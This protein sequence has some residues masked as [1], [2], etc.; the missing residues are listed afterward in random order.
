M[1]FLYKIKYTF[2]ILLTS[3]FLSTCAVISDDISCQFTEIDCYRFD[4]T[5]IETFK[6]SVEDHSFKW[7]L[8]D[9]SKALSNQI[10]IKDLSINSLQES[11]TFIENN[12]ESMFVL[13]SFLIENQKPREWLFFSEQAFIR[14]FNN[15]SR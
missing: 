12:P 8:S 2:F 1:R 13:G 14:S 3:F 7:S 5:S 15:L 11:E 4:Y 9:P 6:D 10:L